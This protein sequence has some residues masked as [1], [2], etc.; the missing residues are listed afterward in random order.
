MGTVAKIVAN[1]EQSKTL[2]TAT[3]NVL[4]LALDF[5]NLRKEVYQ[6]GSRIPI[7]VSVCFLWQSQGKTDASAWQ[8]FGTP[9]EDAERRDTTINSLFFNVHTRRV[10]DWTRQGLP[11]LRDGLIRTPLPALRTF[12]DDPLRV[13]R[14]VRFAARFG[15]RLDAGITQCL[16]GEQGESVRS[17]LAGKVSRE[18]FGI[19][20]DKMLGGE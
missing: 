11:D 18:R 5:V 3:A 1:P 6:E 16:G 15:Y 20:V 13:L 9:H 14:C 19:E 8:S 4:G 12:L 10:E 17:A 7:M 2:E